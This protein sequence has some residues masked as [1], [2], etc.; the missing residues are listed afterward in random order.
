MI[1]H[2]LL[3]LTPLIQSV[4]WKDRELKMDKEK[5]IFYDA[6]VIYGTHCH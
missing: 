4:K 1:N 5:C 6:Q 3:F 2:V